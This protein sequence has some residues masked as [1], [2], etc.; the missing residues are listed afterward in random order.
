LLPNFVTVIGFDGP[1]HFQFVAGARCSLRFNGNSGMDTTAVARAGNERLGIT[2]LMRA[3]IDEDLTVLLRLL[4]TG[5]YDANLFVRDKKGRTALD[6]ARMC[7]NYQ[8]VSVLTQAMLKG[9]ADS[10]L[11]AM[12]SPLEL[13]VYIK[14]TN[15]IQASDLFQAIRNRDI[16]K[17]KRIL[18]ENKLYREEVEGLGEV[19]FTDAPG[20]SG[21]TPL[22]LAAGFNMVEVV[23]SLLEYKVPID[24]ENKFGHTAFTYACAAGNSDVT[25]LLLFFGADVHHR[26]KEGRTGLHY[27]CMYAKARTVKVILY[28]LLERFATFRI[29]GHSLIEFEPSRW[30]KYAE[31]LEG[32]INVSRNFCLSS[33]YYISHKFVYILVQTRDVNSKLATDLIPKTFPDPLATEARLRISGATALPRLK[34]SERDDRSL[35]VNR[36]YAQSDNN[37]DEASV[38]S[39]LGDDFSLDA[40]PVDAGDGVENVYGRAGLPPLRT[41]VLEAGEQPPT[42]GGGDTA[43]DSL[44]DVSIGDYENGGLEGYNTATDGRPELTGT[45]RGNI[46]LLDDTSRVSD[47]S[48]NTFQSAAAFTHD[49]DNLHAEGLHNLG[50]AH[51]VR[52]AQ[53]LQEEV[54]LITALF[55]ETRERIRVWLEAAQKE[56][57]LMRLV[58][59]PLNCNLMCKIESLTFHVRDD[60]PFRSLQCSL[61]RKMV[62]FI[63]LKQHNLKLCQKRPIACPNAYQGCCERITPDTIESHVML[64]CKLRK[65]AC[66]Q[67]CGAFVPCCKR[68]DHELHHCKR[69]TIQC[70]QCKTSMGA[71]QYTEHLHQHCPQRL[72]KCRVSCGQSFRAHEIEAHE[73]DVC[74]RACKWNCGQR[75]GPSEQLALHEANLCVDKPMQC[76]H[77][78]G[79]GHLT[80]KDVRVHE[81]LLCDKR[82]VLCSRG[83]GAVLQAS[84][85]AKHLE[86]FCGTCFERPVRCPSNLV[87]WRIM[88]LPD[89]QEGIVLQYRRQSVTVDAVT[90]E[91]AQGSA[92]AASLQPLQD[93]EPLDV[94]NTVAGTDSIVGPTTSTRRTKQVQVD[95]IFLR[96]ETQQVWVDY[97]TTHYTLLRKVQGEHLSKHEH[98]D[99]KFAC[100]WVTYSDMNE[101]LLHHCLN[102]EIRVAGDNDRH[103]QFVGQKTKFSEAVTTAEKRLKF[104][105][106]VQSEVVQKSTEFCGFCSAEIDSL[107]L[108]AHHKDDC[109]EYLVKCPFIC[110]NE[111]RR[112]ELQRHVDEHCPKRLVLCVDCNSKDL[113]AEE[114]VTHKLHQCDMRIVPCPLEC[115]DP[116]VSELCESLQALLGT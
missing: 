94:V 27:C 111:V 20:H 23:D 73:R 28:F 56:S 50:D 79:V 11:D 1:I 102:R 29:E 67:F 106:F 74:V 62:R 16:T 2:A 61:C 39:D 80:V 98:I 66:R 17:A 3:A 6:W 32:L 14:E 26:T 60:C 9:I 63:D 46:M 115:D 48:G 81:R 37:M 52:T 58:P 25:R 82:K 59:C 89:Q 104:D 83:C 42:N 40:D 65:L 77:G 54:T 90:S 24:A 38:V 31:I 97:W 92:P 55:Q 110:G 105:H 78:C 99:H 107:L 71:H 68:E 33:T 34:Q 15:K 8:A 43:R 93:G 49:T 22:T 69:R 35:E 45:A 101:H 108:P 91:P 44:A 30:T 70:D 51:S 109:P 114:L 36:N 96:M 100:G 18:S 87:G 85:H 113:W 4:L 116:Q 76:K 86:S 41:S 21:Y 57:E 72:M 5:H 19:F 47:V 12:H 7:R 13:E 84:Q 64:K 103:V 75:I 95:Q 88:L 53:P 10:R 112:R